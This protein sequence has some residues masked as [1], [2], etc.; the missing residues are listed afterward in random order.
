MAAQKLT[1]VKTKLLSR[2]RRIIILHLFESRRPPIRFAKC[3]ASSPLLGRQSYLPRLQAAEP[4][5]FSGTLDGGHFS[6][7]ATVMLRNFKPPVWSP[8]M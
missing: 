2:I 8:C 5:G 6:G 3:A 4:N 1:P 7:S